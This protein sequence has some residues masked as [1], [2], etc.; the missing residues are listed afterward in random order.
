MAFGSGDGQ[1]SADKLTLTLRE[2]VRESC[3]RGLTTSAHSPARGLSCCVYCSRG[4]GSCQNRCITAA[5]ARKFKEAPSGC[6]GLPHKMP[7]SGRPVHQYLNWESLMWA[8]ML[9][10]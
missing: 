4:N 9:L 6:H 7:R 1:R 3:G 8:T 2:A 10:G 5:A